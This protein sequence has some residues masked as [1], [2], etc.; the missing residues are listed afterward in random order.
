MSE[1]I[2][3]VAKLL[4]SMQRTLKFGELVMVRYAGAGFAFNGDLRNLCRS[5]PQLPCLGR[6]RVVP[7]SESAVPS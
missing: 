5:F 6:Q 3:L 7:G 1:E 2:Q 4:S